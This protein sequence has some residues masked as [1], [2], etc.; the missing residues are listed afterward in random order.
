MRFKD[1]TESDIS[2]AKE[3]YLNK[4]MSWDDRM[5]SLKALFGKSERTV[6]KWCSEKLGF[7]EKVE[8]E[9][10]QYQSA[11]QRIVDKSKKRFIIT[12]GQNNTPVH[13]GFYDN[14]EAY[15]KFIGADIHI[16]LGRYQNPTSVFNDR[17]EDFG[18]QR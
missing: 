14:M 18:Y 11:K 2:K 12:W 13:K 5:E 10:E 15:A 8:V 7:K 3:I 6:R 16:I 17:D 1:L 4:E 9:P